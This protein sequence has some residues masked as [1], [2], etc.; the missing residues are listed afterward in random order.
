M[1]QKGFLC[2]NIVI[3]LSDIVKKVAVAYKEFF[4]KCEL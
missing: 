2:Y 3:G 1:Q 4:Q